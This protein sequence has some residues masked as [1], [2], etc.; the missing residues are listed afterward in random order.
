MLRSHASEANV[1][2]HQTLN[3]D[4]GSSNLSACMMR[5]R[6]VGETSAS[7]SENGGSNPSIAVFVPEAKVVEAADF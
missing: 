5:S 1:E 6:L 4:I 3:L 2:L 7:E